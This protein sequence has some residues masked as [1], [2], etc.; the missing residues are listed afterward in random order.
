MNSSN[1]IV[2]SR[3]FFG[4][5]DQYIQFF[6]KKWG[7]ITTLAKAA[8]KSRRRY[9]GGLDLFC[10]SEIFIRG[11]PRENPYLS[12]LVVLNSFTGIRDR[13]ER[14]LV[15]GKVTQ[16]IRSLAN[17]AV[18]MPEVFSLL[19]QTLSLTERETEPLRLEFLALVFKLKL[20]SLLGLR[21]NTDR[22]LK[23]SAEESAS[24]LFD[25]GAGGTICESC[26]HGALQ[27]Y[28]RLSP[29]QHSLLKSSEQI[30]LTRWPDYKLSA[31]EALPLTQIITHFASF[32]THTRLPL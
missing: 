19:G 9:A 7:M 1:A 15:A 27:D 17:T 3:N 12:E 31:E 30:R 21:P 13:L 29:S 10:H 5:A 24:F 2:V 22:C 16:W 28:F 4:E 32:H 11:D 8:R 14:L 25:V 18:S 23:C 26:A 20:L 6:T